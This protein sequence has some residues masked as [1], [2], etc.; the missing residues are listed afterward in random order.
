MD[1][2]RRTAVIVG[3][4]YIIGTAAGVLS[5]LTTQPVLGSPDYLAMI[6]ADNTPILAGILL[7]LTMGFALAVIPV[8]LYPVLKKQNEVLAL[9]YVV[10][11]GAL[12]MVMYI[13]MA[14]VWSFLVL[15]GRAYG[16]AAAADVSVLQTLG[17][18]LRES[19]DSIADIL[20]IVF[21]LDA[22]MLYV[23]LYQS[24]LVPRWISVWGFI[25]ILMHFSTAFVHMFHLVEPGMS[26]AVDAVN[27]PIFLQEMVMAVWLIARGFDPAA[28]KTLAVRS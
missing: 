23:L 25:A 19:N 15:V 22:L 16:G 7:V 27:L 9:G 10:F 6:A 11:R 5:V 24:R 18:I 3:I 28:M 21:S 8:I 1:V 13:A 4:L 26:A 14:A 12:E 17:G 2:K 20:V